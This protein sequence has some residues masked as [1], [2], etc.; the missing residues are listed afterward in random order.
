MTAT[1]GY[2]QILV[3]TWF[4]I[5]E[6]T[7]PDIPST[8][9]I[10]LERW[11][12]PEA[13]S[14]L[15]L[16]SEIGNPW[17][18]SGRLRKSSEELNEILRSANNEVWLFKVGEMTAGFFELVHLTSATEVLY[19]GL[20]PEW[21][22]KGLGDKLIQSAIAKAGQTGKKVWLHTCEYD[23]PSA[24]SAYLKAGFKIEKELITQEYYP[25]HYEPSNF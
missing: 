5:F 1:D 8:N 16:Y 15:E 18:W 10:L 24:L 14:Y 4:L 17:G 23:H 20:K 11:E 7:L 19:L 13:H 3:K 25:L 21:I 2:K 22:G 6:G 9:S 12:N